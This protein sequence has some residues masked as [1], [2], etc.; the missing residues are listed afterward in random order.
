[1]PEWVGPAL[2]ALSPVLTAL[3]TGVVTWRWADAERKALQEQVKSKD[4]QL[5]AAQEGF[6]GQIEALKLANETLKLN[7]VKEV[8]ARYVILRETVKEMGG[9]EERLKAQV[10]ELMTKHDAAM[11]QQ[12]RD[13]E[14]VA[15]LDWQGRETAA[16]LSDIIQTLSSE[17]PQVREAL[18]KLTAGEKAHPTYLQLNSTSG[19][20]T[21]EPPEP[22]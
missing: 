15:R 19:R 20:E 21:L 9:I 10:L 5:A 13:R 16:S 14:E 17:I 1:M 7:D 8:N 4:A 12:R 22:E 2:V 18:E 11:F 6:K 3:I